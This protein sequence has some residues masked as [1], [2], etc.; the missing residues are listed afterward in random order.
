MCFYRYALQFHR[1]T[2][3]EIRE[4][5][6]AARKGLVPVQEKDLE[7]DSDIF[8]TPDLDFPTR[9]PWNHNMTP[10]ELDARE[11]RYFTVSQTSLQFAFQLQSLF[12]CQNTKN[13]FQNY[14]NEM[15]TIDFTMFEISVAMNFIFLYSL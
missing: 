4:R 11:H 8:F 6:E 14:F 5:K 1:E 3:A 7:I 2:E 9:P 15:N 13:R 10:A 12:F